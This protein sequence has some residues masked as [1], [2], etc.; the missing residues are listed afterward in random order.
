MTTA[1]IAGRPIAPPPPPP[2][3]GASVSAAAPRASLAALTAPRREGYRPP[4]SFLIGPQKSGK[5]TLAAGSARPYFVLADPG[6]LDGLPEAIPCA[7]V[8][9]WDLQA[10]ERMP[11]PNC[12][13]ST[14][15]HGGQ[16]QS[17]G[18]DVPPRPTV[19]GTIDAPL[20]DE[21]DFTAVALDTISKIEAMLWDFRKVQENVK[22]VV[23]IDNGFGAGYTMAK[24][25]MVRLFDKCARIRDLRG[26]EI[27]AMAHQEPK[28]QHTADG[29]DF[30]QWA[31]DLHK[32]AAA[33]WLGG[34]DIILYVEKEA[35]DI[36][37]QIKKM[38]SVETVMQREY[39]GRSLA[40]ARPTRGREAGNRYCLPGVMMLGYAI[41]RSELERGRDIQ[42]QMWAKLRAMPLPERAEAETFL[43]M[44]GWTREAHEDV[45]SGS[46][47]TPKKGK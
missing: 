1:P 40:Y 41:F 16:C 30:E 18:F 33:V 46:Y 24:E 23:K 31:A 9:A 13:A 35:K 17:C 47:K 32:K 44:A 15:A 34:A 6:G 2:K 38:G 10:G 14:P 5:S 42:G 28:S 26:C 19:M 43:A 22:S 20:T 25:H 4:I 3:N 39:T 21:H 12:G 45:I 36:P 7:R 11:C 29:T 37:V 27:F 8:E